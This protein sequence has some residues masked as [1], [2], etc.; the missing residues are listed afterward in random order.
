MTR[1][2]QSAGPLT[3]LLTDLENQ[4]AA[5]M[6]A[7]A[8]AMRFGGLR[9]LVEL[10]LRRAHRT[11]RV[12]FGYVLHRCACARHRRTQRL[13]VG[14]IGLRRLGAGGDEGRTAAGLEHRER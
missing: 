5:E 12:Q 7:F 10:D 4:L 6:P 2:T 14:A 8:D 13:H 9:K 11:R 1:P 3:R